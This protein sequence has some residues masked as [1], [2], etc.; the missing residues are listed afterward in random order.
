MFFFAV[1]DGAFLSLVVFVDSLTNRLNTRIVLF[2][3]FVHRQL[4]NRIYIP[5]QLCD[6][7][8]SVDL[9]GNRLG[10][11]PFP[12]KLDYLQRLCICWYV[13]TDRWSSPWQSAV[14]VP[15]I[16]P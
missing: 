15:Y 11:R 8:V 16:I 9:K 7:P 6:V 5:F 10:D 1:V 13:L 12:R 3:L 4:S 2:A 14:E